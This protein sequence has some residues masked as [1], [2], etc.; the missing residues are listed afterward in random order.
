MGCKKK[1]KTLMLLLHVKPNRVVIYFQ[2]VRGSV[3]G[4]NYYDLGR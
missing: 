1:K 4:K 2:V 3:D